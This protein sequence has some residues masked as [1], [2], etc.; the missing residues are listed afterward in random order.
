MIDLAENAGGA[1]FFWEQK[2]TGCNSGRCHF[3]APVGGRKHEREY[4]ED[5]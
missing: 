1:E 5:T 4:W 3:G 2:C